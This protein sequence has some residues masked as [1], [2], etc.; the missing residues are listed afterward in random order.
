M[1]STLKTKPSKFFRWK[2]KVEGATTEKAEELPYPD[3]LT[4]PNAVLG[5]II[6]SWRYGH[7]PDYSNTRKVYA[8]GMMIH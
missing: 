1:S 5:D 4:D 7:A 3:Y 6:P 8:R 2:R